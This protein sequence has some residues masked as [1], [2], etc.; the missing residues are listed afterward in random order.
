MT[1]MN[2]FSREVRAFVHAHRDGWNHNEWLGFIDHLR[3][4]GCES[5]DLDQVGLT[6]EKERIRALLSNSGIRGL[7]PKRIEAIAEEFS[8]WNQLL[9]ADP[10]DLSSR[11]GVPFGIAREVLEHAA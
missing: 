2:G 3:V 9:E 10:S 8:S 11:T 5:P 1:E 7:G 4:L 6:L